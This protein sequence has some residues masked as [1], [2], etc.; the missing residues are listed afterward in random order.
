MN[1]TNFNFGRNTIMGKKKVKV[2]D[3]KKKMDMAKTRY[4]H[5]IKRFKAMGTDVKK[6]VL[7]K[8]EKAKKAAKTRYTNAKNRYTDA[9]KTTTKKMKSKKFKAKVKKVALWGGLVTAAAAT[10]VAGLLIKSKVNGKDNGEPT[11]VV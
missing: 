8:A 2:S 7:E 11:D 5:A 1:F 10:A 4:E 3:L 6:D 9:K